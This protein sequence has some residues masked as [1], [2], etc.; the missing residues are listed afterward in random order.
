MQVKEHLASACEAKLN[1]ALPPQKHV[2]LPDVLQEHIARNV[3]FTSTRQT[4]RPTIEP[5]QPVRIYV[6]HD[7]IEITEQHYPPEY[8]SVNN[9]ITY[10]MMVKPSEH[11]GEM[12]LLEFKLCKKSTFLYR[13]SI[14]ISDFRFDQSS[15]AK[16]F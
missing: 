4:F 1:K 11:Q 13:L 2:L 7:N 10:S 12:N 9:A 6:V 8:S 5:L 15:F 16:S 14:K 3:A